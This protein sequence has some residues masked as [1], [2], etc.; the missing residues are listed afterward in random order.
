M[1]VEEMLDRLS[2][3]EITEW[4]EEYKLRDWERRRDKLLNGEAPNVDG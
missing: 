1:G 4:E 2:S 3:A